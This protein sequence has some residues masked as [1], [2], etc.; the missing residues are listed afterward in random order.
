MPRHDEISLTARGGNASIHYWTYHAEA[1]RESSRKSASAQNTI[2]MIH[3]FR[4]DHHGMRLIAE[5]LPDRRVIVPDLPG[6]GLSD[7]WPGGHTLTDFI[8]FLDAFLHGLD[9][10]EHPVIVGHSFGSI[11]CAE[12]AA[13]FP[14]ELSA[15]ILINPISAP[16]LSGPRAL[17]TKATLG[18]YKTAAALPEKIGL[19]LLRAPAIVRVMSIAMAKTRDPTLRRY[20]HAQHDAHFSSFTDRRAL[21]DTFSTSVSHTAADRACEIR[22]PTMIIAGGRDDISTLAD[23]ECL[24]A[25]IPQAAL[26]VVARAGH[27]IHYEAPALTAAVIEEFLA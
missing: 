12:F 14:T 18:Y 2:V 21:L 15:L 9:L 1:A 20:I 23:Q 4:G 16:A 27:L 5:A 3:G 22:S 6:F 13:R 11:I 24:A 26:T 8:E 17:A 10:P 25:T 7:P 19:R